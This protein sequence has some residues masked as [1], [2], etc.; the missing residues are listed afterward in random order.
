MKFEMDNFVLFWPGGNQEK[1]VCQK[2]KLFGRNFA[3]QVSALAKVSFFTWR[4]DFK[5]KQGGRWSRYEENFSQKLGVKNILV[6]SA[7]PFIL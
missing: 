7:D 5:S 1:K 3:K 4:F 6:E 2:K